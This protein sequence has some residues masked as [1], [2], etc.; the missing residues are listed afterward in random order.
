[1][2]VLYDITLEEKVSHLLDKTNIK[3]V[4]L[5]E[6]PHPILKLQMLFRPSLLGC[7]TP[8]FPEVITI[9][10]SAIVCESIDFIIL[11][12]LGHAMSHKYGFQPDITQGVT[13]EQFLTEE[14][15][16]DLFAMTYMKKHSIEIPFK[17]QNNLK[18]ALIEIEEHLGADIRDQIF[19]DAS[20][21]ALTCLAM[22]G[23]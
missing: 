15:S 21:R 14:L 23:E 5:D 3:A 22:I 2:T 18:R 20:D 9:N 1:M 7:F 11:H 6:T 13:K 19:A 10:I 16:A 17:F 8:A 4:T 12:E